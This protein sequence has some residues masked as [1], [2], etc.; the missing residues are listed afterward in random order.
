VRLADDHSGST[1]SNYR[2]AGFRTRGTCSNTVSVPEQTTRKPIL[3]AIRDRLKDKALRQSVRKDLG[4]RNT[5]LSTE[6]ERCR[7]HASETKSR[8]D[9]LVGFVEVGD[10]S[11]AITSRLREL[12][13]VGRDQKIELE[14][15][16]N[17]SATHAPSLRI[18]DLDRVLPSI[19]TRL[20]VN[21]EIGRATLRRW[22][23]E[24]AIRIK[25]STGGVRA[26]FDLVAARVVSDLVAHG[27]HLHRLT[28]PS[29]ASV[30]L[31]VLLRSSSSK[32]FTRVL[33][34]CC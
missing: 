24:G 19:E 1:V 22:V 34:A 23:R 31:S 33:L 11:D 29:T 7:S 13:A 12:K 28:A 3:D 6:I 9:E 8:I 14:Q 25:R 26:E 30:S 27:Q 18:S 32:L 10:R 20:L 16:V 2:C 15:L 4:G 17:V 21:V 5:V